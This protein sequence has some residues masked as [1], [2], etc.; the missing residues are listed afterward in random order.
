[1]HMQKWRLKMAWMPTGASIDDVMDVNQSGEVCTID[2]GLGHGH[3]K[4]NDRGMLSSTWRG[5]IIQGIV[6]GHA[7]TPRQETSCQRIAFSSNL[8]LGPSSLSTEEEFPSFRHDGSRRKS[9]KPHG[10]L[11]LDGLVQ[12]CS[13]HNNTPHCRRQSSTPDWC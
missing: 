13:A 1:M 10:N 7:H 9:R 6:N 4:S 11:A 12:A 2:I 3:T 8:K 5:S